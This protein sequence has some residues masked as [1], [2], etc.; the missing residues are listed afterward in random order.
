VRVLVIDIGG[1]HVKI[2]VSGRRTP[3]KISSGPGLTARQMVRA[4]RAAT[5]DWSYDV[6]SIGYPGV[7][8]DGKPATEPV[9]L[10]P[11]WVGFDF[12]RA[13]DCPVKV[14]NDAAMQALGAYQG[15]RMLFFGLGTGFGSALIVD[16]ALE[17]MELGHL[18]Y[19]KGRTFEQYVG[20][21]G[22]KRL[23]RKKWRR[24]VEH[25]VTRLKAALQA[26]EVVLG[27]GNV[28]LLE[29]L[30]AGARRGSNADAFVGGFRLWRAPWSTR[31]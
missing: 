19:R 17:P 21:A 2:L 22:L 1:S 10:G 4:V 3:I 25:V 16:G 8:V 14:I 13:F 27:G 28:K 23:G 30:P 18:P 5:A 29:E 6:V 15:G 20:K 12:R 26:D 24:H 11:G 31:L 9:N 7:V